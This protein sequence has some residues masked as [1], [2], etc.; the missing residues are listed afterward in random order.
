MHE[1]L[2]LSY[3]NLISSRNIALTG[4]SFKR[5]SEQWLAAKLAQLC[6]IFEK[7]LSKNLHL[8]SGLED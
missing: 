2:H 1:T 3:L 7:Y 5:C 8:N 4:A 6:K